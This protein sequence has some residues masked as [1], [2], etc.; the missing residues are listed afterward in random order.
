METALPTNDDRLYYA[1]KEIASYEQINHFVRHMANLIVN[2]DLT[3]TNI[4]VYLSE[5]DIRSITTIKI[6]MLSMIIMYLNIMLDDGIITDEIKRNVEILK[7]YFKIKEGDFHKKNYLEIKTIIQRQL[8]RLYSDNKLSPE[9]AMVEVDLQDMFD[10]SLAQFEE[11]KK[12]VIQR[13]IE[14]GAT[15]EDINPHVSMYVLK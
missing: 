5:Y 2:N 12:E 10:L 1:F 7:L 13:A 9:E 6:E 4:K 8:E 15:Y 11:I 3:T 14:R